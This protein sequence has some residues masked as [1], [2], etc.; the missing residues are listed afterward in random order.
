MPAPLLQEVQIAAPP[1]VVGFLRILL[2][3]FAIAAF[4]I[5]ALH[6]QTH[7]QRI[8]HRDDFVGT[9]I[10]VGGAVDV[11]N[12]FQL[13]FWNW[14]GREELWSFADPVVPL[15]ARHEAE[16]AVLQVMINA[17]D[18]LAERYPVQLV[19]RNLKIVRQSRVVLLGEADLDAGRENAVRRVVNNCAILIELRLTSEDSENSF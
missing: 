8:V 1:T 2:G 18:Q 3:R 15:E 14:L 7:V 5:I 4:G 13:D 6:L 19:L 16:L 11:L 17:Q 9:Q 12:M 10:Q